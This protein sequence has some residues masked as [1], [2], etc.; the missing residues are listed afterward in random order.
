MH[1]EAR[2]GKLETIEMLFT[3]NA[4]EYIPDNRGFRPIDYAGKFKHYDV[5]KLLVEKSKF[6]IYDSSKECIMRNM[7]E[8]I[9]GKEFM[10]K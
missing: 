8:R 5:C 2:Y 4:V 3:C 7:R 6:K 1:W 10:E 9:D